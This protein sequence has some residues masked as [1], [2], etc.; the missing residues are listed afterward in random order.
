MI[1]T[2]SWFLNVSHPLNVPTSNSQIIPLASPTI[3]LTDN[4]TACK[5]THKTKLRIND[6]ISIPS[7]VTPELSNVLVSVHD[8]TKR[9]G[10]V[11]FTPRRAFILHRK[12]VSAL[13]TWRNPFYKIDN[14]NQ[15]HTFVTKPNLPSSPKPPPTFRARPISKTSPHIIKPLGST[16]KRSNIQ[17]IL[18]IPALTITERRPPLPPSLLLKRTNPP[19]S[20]PN[21]GIYSPYR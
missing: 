12:K 11:L 1:A 2:V 4:K 8:V 3:T 19:T 13:A 20:P 21:Q 16:P 14:D 18:S 9:A 7:L 6:S 10:P 5:T 15:A 17:N